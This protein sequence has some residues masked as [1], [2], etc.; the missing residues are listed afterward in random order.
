MVY[1]GATNGVGGLYEPTT[2]WDDWANT[3]SYFEDCAQYVKTVFDNGTNEFITKVFLSPSYAS[4]DYTFDTWGAAPTNLK[5]L[6]QKSQYA[7]IFGDV[8]FNVFLI[9]AF[10]W[11][12]PGDRW[13]TEF[14]MRDYPNFFSDEYTETYNLV[15]H[16]LDTYTTGKTFVI[17]NWEGDWA[18]LAST[19]IND[20]KT[21][22]NDRIENLIAFHQVRQQAV[23]DAVKDSTSGSVALYAPEV[24]RVVDCLGNPSARRVATKVLKRLNIDMVSYSAYDS[25]FGLQP[26]ESSWHSTQAEMLIRT[27]KRFSDTIN[28]LREITGTN[29]VISEYGLPLDE[30]P[31]LY[32][33]DAIVSAVFA[34][35]ETLN[36]WGAAYWQVIDNENRGFELYDSIGTKT[37]LATTF[38]GL[39]A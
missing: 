16:L 24:N 12:N 10:S 37:S 1:H 39:V 30:V 20:S 15:K 8:N 29:V 5:E 17:T 14:L 28:F 22:H 21:I 38:Q 3:G 18:L 11:N 34:Q 23:R 6:A 19:D 27:S 4:A 13:R 26:G 9:T 7:N 32:S 31:G 35:M 33:A 2:G 25:L 36:V